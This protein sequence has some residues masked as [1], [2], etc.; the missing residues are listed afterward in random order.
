MHDKK[1]NSGEFEID[2][3]VQ[4]YDRRLQEQVALAKMDIYHALECQ[5]QVNVGADVICL[6][7]RFLMKS[8]EI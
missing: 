1:V 5:I 3:V 7:F 6:L 8:I 2:E 4:S